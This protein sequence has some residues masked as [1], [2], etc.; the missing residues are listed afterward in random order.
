[1]PHPPNLAVCCPLR[2]AANFLV[3][4]GL[5]LILFAPDVKAQSV[6]G[7]QAPAKS[8]GTI[9]ESAEVRASRGQAPLSKL[10]SHLKVNSAK[11]ARLPPPT[12]GEMQ[13]EPSE[14]VLRIGIIRALDGPLDPLTDGADYLV[15]EGNV[16]V[17][18]VVSEAALSTRV[19]FTQMSLPAGAR[20]F[21]YS[22]KNPDD[23]YGPYEGHG[24]SDAG[25]FW[26]P[27]LE[28]E[29]VVIEARASTGH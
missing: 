3:V 8:K 17:L 27:P 21:V 19:H 9:Q 1:M 18:G 12:A 29:G 20:V 25:T 11:I 26:T 4:L 16:H 2:L 10:Y 7:F 6:P 15:V 14:K 24:P 5:F 22:M 23:F 13:K 28:G